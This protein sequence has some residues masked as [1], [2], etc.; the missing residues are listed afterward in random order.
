MAFGVESATGWSPQSKT[1][2][3]G[4]E[5]DDVGSVPDLWQHIDKIASC[6]L[7]YADD[8]IVV[9]NGAEDGGEEGGF[10]W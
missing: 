3:M 8:V 2:G 5:M 7:G 9:G 6:R 10:A 4:A 1:T